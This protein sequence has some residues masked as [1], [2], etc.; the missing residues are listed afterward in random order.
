[1]DPEIMGDMIKYDNTYMIT[2]I[3][4]TLDLTDNEINNVID[5]L[6]GKIKVLREDRD[7]S[8]VLVGSFGKD[9]V[10]APPL[11]KCK[12]DSIIGYSESCAIIP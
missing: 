4:K 10:F 8:I 7:D 12:I 2:G 1:M 11:S 6:N 9:Y 3:R 5:N